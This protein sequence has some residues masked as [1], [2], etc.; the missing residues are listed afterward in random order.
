MTAKP[1]SRKD[2]ANAMLVAAMS[3]I[4]SDICQLLREYEAKVCELEDELSELR[5][6][7]YG[8]NGQLA[9]RDAEILEL[10]AKN[11]ALAASLKGYERTEGKPYYQ[12]EI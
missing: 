8:P 9:L 7:V 11:E 3:S 4:D 5:A 1:I 6:I 2:R 10:K 12:D